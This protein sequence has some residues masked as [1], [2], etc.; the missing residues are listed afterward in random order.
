MTSRSPAK[1]RDAPPPPF[2][3]KLS[4]T[5]LLVPFG[6]VAAFLF[7]FNAAQA[8]ATREEGWFFMMAAAV[9]SI[10]G[11]ALRAWT[12]DNSLA[13]LEKRVRQLEVESVALKGK[14]QA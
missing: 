3:L 8:G 5:P 12:V 10:I 1:S 6:A 11:Y 4:W 9:V 14:P 7:G 2:R 13:E